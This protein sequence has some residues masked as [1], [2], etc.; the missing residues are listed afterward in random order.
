M[1]I[2]VTKSVEKLVILN[3]QY[4]GNCQMQL[5]EVFCKKTFLKNFAIFTEKH[6]C[7]SI[8]YCKILKN[9]YF[10]R[11]LQTAV[12]E[13]YITQNFTN[14]ILMIVNNQ[15][16]YQN[17]TKITACG[18]STVQAITLQ[19]YLAQISLRF[20]RAFPKLSGQSYLGKSHEGCF[21]DNK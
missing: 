6:L 3:C 8:E 10:E 11:Y 14:P 9:A 7:W 17:D 20:P 18:C 1:C 2:K 4:S 21:E 12:S 15:K 13:F 5:S 19:F 16:F